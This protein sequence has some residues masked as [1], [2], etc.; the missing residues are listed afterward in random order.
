VAFGKIGWRI[1]LSSIAPRPPTPAR[2][3]LCVTLSASSRKRRRSLR[4]RAAWAA[5]RRSRRP[6]G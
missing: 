2:L 3:V 6:G 4:S 5:I 1:T